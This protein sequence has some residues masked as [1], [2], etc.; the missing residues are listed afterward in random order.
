[1]VRVKPRS[2]FTFSATAFRFDTP[3]PNWRSVTFLMF[4]AQIVGKPV[5]APLPAATPVVVRKARRPIRRDDVGAM[6][7]VLFCCPGTIRVDH[8]G[9]CMGR[10]M[11]RAQPMPPAQAMPR[12]QARPAA[13]A[14]PIANAVCTPAAPPRPCVL[15]TRGG[16][17]RLGAPDMTNLRS[18]QRQTAHDCMLGQQRVRSGQSNDRSRNS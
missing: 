9:G 8:G 5:M 18:F 14:V 1:M 3:V 16:T 13:Q 17:R 11:W 7:V 4:C 2:C 10:A 6:G 15:Y 12:A